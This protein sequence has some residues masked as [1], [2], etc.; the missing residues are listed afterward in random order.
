MLARNFGPAAAAPAP[1]ALYAC[2]VRGIQAQK[3]QSTIQCE[4]TH[5]RGREK[6]E[7]MRL[8]VLLI[9]VHLKNY[10]HLDANNAAKV[11]LVN[12]L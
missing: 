3:N 1:T 11:A 9:Y 5:V 7:L 2:R 12:L 4:S 10:Q 6:V 8:V